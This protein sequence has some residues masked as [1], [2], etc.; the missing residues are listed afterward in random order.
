MQ[1]KKL[2]DILEEINHKGYITRN[3]KCNNADQE[4]INEL[5]KER[6]YQSIES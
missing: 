4:T 3:T 5:E 6:Y 2:K 1:D